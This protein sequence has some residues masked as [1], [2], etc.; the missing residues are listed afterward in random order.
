MNGQVLLKI[1][2]KNRLG[3]TCGALSLVCAVIIFL[4]SEAI[5]TAEALLAQ[6]SAE[7]EKI[8]TNIQYSA[9]LKEQ[10]E[11]LSTANKEIES[12]I[13]RASQLLTN[14]QYFYKLESETGVKML[15][16]IR[17]VTSSSVSKPAKGNY[18]P[19]AFSVSVQGDLNQ[20]LAFLRGL[21]SGTHYCRVLSATFSVNSAQRNSPLTLA[22]SL[23][24]LGT[25]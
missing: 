5:P 14:T 20:I 2:K 6:K 24:L 16:S 7:G 25:P 17:Q 12:R 18:L 21:E 3:V 9:Q 11:T 23:E 8:A 15:D 10:V 1:I 19:V 22:L 13:L 4:R